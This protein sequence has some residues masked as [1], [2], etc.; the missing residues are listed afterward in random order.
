M[1]IVQA[2]QQYLNRVGAAERQRLGVDDDMIERPWVDNKIFETLWSEPA[3]AE[4]L[5]EA[6]RALRNHPDGEAM[7]VG[8]IERA[9]LHAIEYQKQLARFAP[10]AKPCLNP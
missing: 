10:E 9:A 3:V 8:E 4:R 1:R 5:L 6:L 7:F 2:M